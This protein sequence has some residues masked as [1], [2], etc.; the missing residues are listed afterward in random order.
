MRDTANQD[1]PL[2]SS[3]ARFYGVDAGNVKYFKCPNC[4]YFQISNQAENYL[5]T[6]PARIRDSFS[7]QA[8]KTPEDHLLVIAVEPSANRAEE[9]SEAMSGKFVPKSKLEL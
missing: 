2:C 7:E 6:A 4:S 8:K 3:V 9:A 1:C 5:K